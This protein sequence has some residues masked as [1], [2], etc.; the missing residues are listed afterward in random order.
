MAFYT[1]HFVPSSGVT[2]IV[3]A[4][5]TVDGSNVTFTTASKPQY[6]MCDGGLYFEGYGYLYSG[7]VITMAF[8]PQSYVKAAL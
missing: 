6:V 4:G 1:E 7:G 8:P 3:D 2:T 5:G